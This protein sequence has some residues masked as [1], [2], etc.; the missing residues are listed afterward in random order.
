MANLPPLQEKGFSWSKPE[1]ERLID[2]MEGNQEALRGSK[3]VW[4]K[5]CKEKVFQDELGVT[6]ERIAAKYNYLKASWRAAKKKLGGIGWG[7]KGPGA[8]TLPAQVEKKCP[9]YTRLD[10][11]FATRPSTSLGTSLDTLN[12][13]RSIAI[14][15]G[16]AEFEVQDPSEYSEVPHQLDDSE[17]D[18][19]LDARVGA[20]GE[21]G[22]SDE[23]LEWAKRTK[24]PRTSSEP[25]VPTQGNG[26]MGTVK[27][28]ME[29]RQSYELQRELKKIK[30][31]QEMQR[32]RLEV[33]ERL[34]RISA[35]A[36]VEAAKIQAEK[37]ASTTIEVAKIQAE[38]Q[39]R[40]FKL[41]TQ[42]LGL[43]GGGGSGAADTQ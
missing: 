17:L 15:P 28:L 10:G 2:W 1:V 25:V 22:N 11:I 30:I 38:A 32:E 37:Q 13:S 34:A 36:A 41:F 14:D 5:D 24:R 19:D 29:E 4:V 18:L 40:Q 43:Q 12:P 9:F 21:A 39:M 3:S 27:R 42:I 7:I 8:G 23:E 16:L 35:S 26:K 31:E 33:K 6:T 20:T